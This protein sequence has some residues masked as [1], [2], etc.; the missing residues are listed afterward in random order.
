MFATVFFGFMPRRKL[1]GN[2]LFTSFG[3]V[4]QYNDLSLT[5]VCGYFTTWENSFPKILSV[6][7][8]LKGSDIQIK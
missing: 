3:F 6:I 4:Y 1:I 8:T 7:V 2:S 5:T